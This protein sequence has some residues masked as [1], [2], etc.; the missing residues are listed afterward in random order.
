MIQ[1]IFIETDF[2][3][4]D[5]FLK[6]AGCVRSGGEGKNAVINGKVLVC[7]KPCLS[8]G[9]KLIKGDTVEFSGEKFEVCRK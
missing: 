1:K 9:K 7:G 8:R 5:S 3:K 4:L 2:I 6:F